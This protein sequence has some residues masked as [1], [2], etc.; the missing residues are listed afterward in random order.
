[1]GWSLSATFRNVWWT[2]LI[3]VT[4][5]PAHAKD[6]RRT[7]YIPCQP[8][9][10]QFCH[11]FNRPRN[12]LGTH[13]H[14]SDDQDKVPTGSSS[15]LVKAIVASKVMFSGTVIVIRLEASV[16]CTD[17]D[18]NVVTQAEE[19]SSVLIYGPGDIGAGNCDKDDKDKDTDNKM[20]TLYLTL[21]VHVIWAEVS[22]Y[23]YTGRDSFHK[24]PAKPPPVKDC[25]K[26][27]HQI[28]IQLCDQDLRLFKWLYKSGWLYTRLTQPGTGQGTIGY[29]PVV[30]N[31]GTLKLSYDVQVNPSTKLGLVKALPAWIGIPFVFEKDSNQKANLDSLTTAVSYEVHAEAAGN[32]LQ[33]PEDCQPSKNPLKGECLLSNFKIRSPEVQVRSGIELAPTTPHDLNTVQAQV[34]KLPIVLN[35]HNQPSSLTI[36][37]IAGFEEVE[38]VETHLSLENGSQF[39]RLVG[40][41]V[42]LRWPYQVTHNFLGDKPITIEYSY[43]SRWLSNPEP[44]TD[45]E[46]GGT[47][48][49][50]SKRQAYER[51]SFNA[52]IS[53][54]LQFKVTVQHGSLPPDFHTLGYSL[55]IG[56]SFSDPGSVE[57]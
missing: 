8:D 29:S 3:F 19:S 18:W 42:S 39:R 49:L 6:Q 15:D 36:Y 17:Y 57:H 51:A 21:P 10:Q 53:S 7:Y 47:E 28:G 20:Q 1:M 37:P 16:D 9:S 23:P 2:G 26:T 30:G 31:S 41:D 4:L 32:L 44:T 5:V 46:N 56:L 54:Y 33:R 35:L 45:I 24:A 27:L 12:L 55:Q 50:S 25:N 52:P 34:V 38:H 13:Q 43:R 11:Y 22:G 14:L 48:I 40:A